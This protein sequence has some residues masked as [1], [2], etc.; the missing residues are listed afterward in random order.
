MAKQD[1]DLWL[2]G[3][4]IT[5]CTAKNCKRKSCLRNEI[6]IRDRSIPHSFSDFWKGDMCPKAWKKCC[7]CGKTI[8]LSDSAIMSGA[9]RVICRNCAETIHYAFPYSVNEENK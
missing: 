6:N 2:L 1:K 9:G 7:F 8:K 3:D 4:D 5:F